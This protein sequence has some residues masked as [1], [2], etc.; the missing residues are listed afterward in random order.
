ML[1]PQ[2]IGG[3]DPQIAPTTYH[4][5]RDHDEAFFRNHLKF[6]DG[7]EAPKGC[8]NVANY[9]GHYSPNPGYQN[10]HRNIYEQAH[11]HYIPTRGNAEDMVNQIADVIQN[12]FGLKLK[13]QRYMYRHLYP[14]W[15][16]QVAIPPRFRVLDFS[17]FS[18]R[19]MCQ[20]LSI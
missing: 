7:Y 19:V 1:N 6:N 12:E 8:D 9:A 13:E 17:K 18:G 16:D 5:T 2:S 15:F 3:H 4:L 20:L 11:G 14:E 10:M